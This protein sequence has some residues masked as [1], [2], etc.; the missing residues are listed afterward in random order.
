METSLI[1]TGLYLV[2]VTKC[3]QRLG[4]TQGN[5]YTKPESR[6]Q[7]QQSDRSQVRTV[8]TTQ[9]Q[10]KIP[11]SSGLPSKTADALAMCA[12]IEVCRRMVYINPATTGSVAKD[13]LPPS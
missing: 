8:A 7:Q 1:E 10:V 12:M 9:L 6:R 5:P 13:L 4:S 2:Q 11:C 3:I